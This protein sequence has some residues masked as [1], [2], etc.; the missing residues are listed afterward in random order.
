MLI[1]N[2]PGT[3]RLFAELREIVS[4]AN[5]IHFASAYV[6]PGACEMFKLSTKS[7]E[8][9]VRLAI[10]RAFIDG[11]ARPAREYFLRLHDVA[12][13]QGGGVTVSPDG[14]HSK[15][16]GTINANGPTGILGS[17]NLTE[18]GMGDWVEANVRFDGEEA[19]LIVNEAKRLYM[20][21]VPIP[22][23]IDQIPLIPTR[24]NPTKDTQDNLPVERGFVTPGMT[25]SLL[26]VRGQV[27]PKSGLNWG[28][29]AGRRRDRYECYI[30]LPKSLLVQAEYVFAANKTGAIFYANTHNGRTLTLKLQGSQ[31]GIYAKQIST[32]GNNSELGHWMIHDCLRI[33][34]TRPVTLQDL[35]NYGRTDV[36]FY[37]TGTHPN[38]NAIV[39]IDFLP[40]DGD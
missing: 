13:A 28:F 39:Y 9:P 20:A 16:Y 21:G 18:N 32:L 3:L 2:F 31:D 11:M 10:G 37:R 8:K 25:I 38:G 15:L 17:S 19:N 30:R 12:L 33:S 40:R 5:E 34:D 4:G 29:A 22:D 14:F 7:Q 23:A 35:L 24:R 36:T 27:P 6:S 26:D 1:T